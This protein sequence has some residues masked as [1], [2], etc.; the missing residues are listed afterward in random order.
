MLLKKKKNEVTTSY[1]INALKMADKN[2]QIADIVSSSILP[3]VVLKRF[4]T[5]A[6]VD[7]NKR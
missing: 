6:F 3:I 1:R 7:T 2:M 4:E 5:E